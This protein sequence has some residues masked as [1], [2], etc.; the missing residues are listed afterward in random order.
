VR[1]IA[2]CKLCGEQSDFI[3]A[4]VIPRSFYPEHGGGK[5]PLSVVSSRTGVRKRRSQIG[6]YDAGL[7][8]AV[9]ER[10]F[11]PYDNYA[12]RLLIQKV[13]EFR[14][15][16]IDGETVAYQIERFDYFK[17]KMFSLSLLWRAAASTRQEFKTVE[18]GRFLP[19]LSTMV[20]KE[21]PGS[22][23]TFAIIICR[24][25]DIGDWHSGVIF[26]LRRR[27]SGC[28]FYK[29][30]MSRY[31][32]YIKVDISPTPSAL[33]SLIIRPDLPLWI[34]AQE[35]KDGPEFQAMLRVLQAQANESR[36]R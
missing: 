16:V 6:I 29:F 25:S 30:V 1:E 3:K 4:H 31:V 19:R 7:V 14:P 2:L 5:E 26:P 21:I 22:P 11:D 32:F 33:N 9:C 24:F 15:V 18:I 10:R 34:L 8:C 35:F 23:E 36:G 27:I 17:L 13:D 28:T 20:R 12:A